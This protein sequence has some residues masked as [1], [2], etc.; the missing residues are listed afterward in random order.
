M[1]TERE[2]LSVYDCAKLINCN[3][4]RIYNAIWSKSLAARQISR[5]WVIHPNDFEA[6][7]REQNNAILAESEAKCQRYRDAL[8]ARGMA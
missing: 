1:I 2:M 5:A 7:C 3:P 8:K 6:Y 4:M